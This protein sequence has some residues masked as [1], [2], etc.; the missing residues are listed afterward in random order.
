MLPGKLLQPYECSVHSKTKAGPCTGPLGNHHRNRNTQSQYFETNITSSAMTTYTRSACYNL[1]GHHCP[2][3]RGII[4]G[5]YKMPQW[6]SHSVAASFTIVFSD[7]YTFLTRFQSS[8]KV[9]SDSFCQV[10]SCFFPSQV[11]FNFFF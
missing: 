6:S 7:S 1:H 4:D 3:E 2:G 8:A 11:V 5:Q 9:D 10:I